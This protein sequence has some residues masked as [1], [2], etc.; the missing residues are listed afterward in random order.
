MIKNILLA[1]LISLTLTGCYEIESNNSSDNNSTQDE[2][3]PEYQQ[4]ISNLE[5]VAS[6]PQEYF[7]LADAYMQRSGLVLSD[8]IQ[9]IS[10]STKDAESPFLAF[11]ASVQPS[12]EAEASSIQDLDKATDYQM[13]IIG[14]RCETNVDLTEFEKEVC[15]YK[16]LAQTMEVANTINSM[17]DD[18]SQ[19]NTNGDAKLQASSCAMQY[20]FN[21]II[22]KYCSISEIGEV[23]FDESA[24]TYDRIAVYTDGKEYEYLLLRDDKMHTREVIVTEGYC[25]SNDFSLRESKLTDNSSYP[26]P[27]STVEGAEQIT[28]NNNLIDSLNEGT[29]AILAVSD[30]YSELAT[31]VQEFRVEI[32][33]V[34]QEDQSNETVDETIPETDIDMQDM[35]EYL[36]EQ[37]TLTR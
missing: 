16:G 2:E 32:S 27:V 34:N 24:T 10:D 4:V 26:C 17:S 28:A 8:V 25:S 1:L 30:N 22:E 23:T 13:L 37:N 19:I 35:I 31:T 12:S 29:D 7:E 15:L 11:V 18:V 33:S 3:I 9:E 20:A 14:D 6:T 36:N 5:G 21:G